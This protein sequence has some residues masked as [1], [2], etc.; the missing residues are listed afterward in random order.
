[1]PT[2]RVGFLLPGPPST[3]VGGYRVVYSYADRLARRGHQVW[4]AHAGRLGQLPPPRPR[5][6]SWPRHLWRTWKRWEPFIKPPAVEWAPLHPGV[7]M[8]YLPGEPSAR[9]LPAADVVVATA[10]PTAEYVAHFGARQGVPFY[11]IQHRETWHGPSERALATWKLPIYKVVVSQWLLDEARRAGETEVRRI[12]S[13][14]EP[15]FLNH[16]PA[17]PRTPSL[18]TPYHPYRW[19]GS[20][21]ALAALSRIHERWPAVPMTAFGAESRPA[22][23]PRWIKYIENPAQEVLAREV[24]GGHSIF[25]GASWQEGFGLMAAEAMACGAVFV[26][27]D[28]GGCRDYADP[29]VTAL[30]SPPGDVQ[31]LVSN[32]EAIMTD[33][34]LLET[35]RRKGQA[36][37]RQF[38]WDRAVDQLEEY[39]QY[40]RARGPLANAPHPAHSGVS[41]G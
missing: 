32:L 4:V 7:E 21:D 2:M 11:L 37:V 22:D 36:R 38:T 15:V 31:A 9:R 40:G 23:W 10:W 35:L 27:T 34:V 8:I 6:P 1:M 39:F 25:V 20:A 33:S 19:K 41:H 18:I 28:S 13:G 26:G 17:A 14:L 5:F 30:L 12:A 3:P 24:Y 16:P 29:G